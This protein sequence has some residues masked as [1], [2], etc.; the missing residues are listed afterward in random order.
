MKNKVENYKYLE[1]HI[2]KKKAKTRERIKNCIDSMLARSEPINIAKIAERSGVSR[3]TIYRDQELRDLIDRFR[4]TSVLRRNRKIKL[5]KEEALERSA[6]AK[7]KILTDKIKS[8]RKVIEDLKKENQSLKE[9]IEYLT[10]KYEN[11]KTFGK[12]D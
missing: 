9:H 3:M 12:R 6:N 2:K 7:L 5:E 4:E 8:E 1:E 10:Q 11:I